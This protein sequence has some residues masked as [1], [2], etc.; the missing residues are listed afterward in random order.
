MLEKLFKDDLA[1]EYVYRLHTF[2]YIYIYIRGGGYD[3]K[4]SFGGT[5]DEPTQL[6]LYHPLTR[7]TLVTNTDTDE[8]FLNIIR[9]IK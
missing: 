6:F 3:K 5:N 7:Y 1:K 8:K 9:R 4:L 2:I